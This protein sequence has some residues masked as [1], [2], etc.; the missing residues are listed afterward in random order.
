MEP[1]GT[2]YDFCA[3]AEMD[4]VKNLVKGSVDKDLNKYK[5]VNPDS[6]VSCVMLKVDNED[7]I[8]TIASQINLT[9]PNFTALT[10]MSLTRSTAKNIDGMKSIFRFI[11]GCVC[12]LVVITL[13]LLYFFVYNEREKDFAILKMLGIKRNAIII[14][15][16]VEVICQALVSTILGVL[17]VFGISFV[18]GPTMRE[19]LSVPVL[20]PSIPNI[21]VYAAITCIISMSSCIVSSA[22]Y[23][24]NNSRVSIS[25]AL[26]ES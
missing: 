6:I 14:T 8:D 17:F 5:D 12:V 25:I 4:T 21:V 22:L 9:S 20:L 3:F 15:S 24:I 16:L 26:K 13:F 19:W 10:N 18:L 23:I 7:D 1:T 11:L 2:S